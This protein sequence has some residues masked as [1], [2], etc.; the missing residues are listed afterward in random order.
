MLALTLAVGWSNTLADLQLL[1][2]CGRCFGIFSSER[3]VS[4]ASITPFQDDGISPG[5]GSPNTAWLSYVVT[6]PAF[7]RRGLARRA[8]VA[9]LDWLDAAHPGA[10]VGL[11]AEPVAGAPLYRMLGFTDAGEAVLW[12]A[13]LAPDDILRAD[14]RPPPAA[15][16]ADSTAPAPATDDGGG[17]GPAGRRQRA[18]PLAFSR[19]T[20][21]GCTG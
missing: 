16:A 20:V 6:L 5:R 21:G 10:A 13:S 15:A 17:E 4:M 18:V 7:R 14:S 9:A 8:C 19:L 3:L 12:Q 11:Y 2:R 1:L